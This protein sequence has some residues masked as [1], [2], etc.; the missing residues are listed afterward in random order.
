MAS[1]KPARK[2]PRLLA[3]SKS[4]TQNYLQGR[5]GD[6]WFAVLPN[7]ISE[8]PPRNWRRRISGTP[9]A[10]SFPRPPWRSLSGSRV[11]TAAENFPAALAAPRFESRQ[12]S[13]QLVQL[14]QSIL[15]G[16]DEPEIS[17]RRCPGVFQEWRVNSCS[18]QA[19]FQLAD[20]RLIHR[21]QPDNRPR[22]FGNFPARR[23]QFCPHIT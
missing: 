23:A 4:K 20:F 16:N 19:L 1:K 17:L 12:H 10:W 21:R 8:L 22:C 3:A 5:G 6:T 15:A 9:A 7:Q 11:S 14:H 13:G 2:T 18:Q